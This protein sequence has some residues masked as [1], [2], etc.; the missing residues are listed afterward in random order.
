M[1]DAIFLVELQF[2]HSLQC[3]V[4]SADGTFR[5]GVDFPKHVASTFRTGQCVMQERT[6][7]V[8]GRHVI[9]RF[10]VFERP[11]LF[12]SIKLAQVVYAWCLCRH[13][14]HEYEREKGCRNQNRSHHSNQ[15]DF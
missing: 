3:M 4:E 11:L 9:G 1:R 5:Q 13:G 15:S 14:P 10:S 8:Q 7:V 12:G 2:R 6:N